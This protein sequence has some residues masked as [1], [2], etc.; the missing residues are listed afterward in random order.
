MGKTNDKKITL[1]EYQKKH[2]RP[3]NEKAAKSF[4]FIFTAAI[5]LLVAFLL[6]SI[7]C[8]RLRTLRRG[9]SS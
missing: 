4:L 9:F 7:W 1:E 2:S 5:G 8:W 6:F 3:V